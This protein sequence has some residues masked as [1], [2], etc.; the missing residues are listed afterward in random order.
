MQ[1]KFLVRNSGVGVEVNSFI[2]PQIGMR[3]AASSHTG[4]ELD[5][6]MEKHIVLE[7]TWWLQAS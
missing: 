6:S 2:D 5:A 4:M 1:G 7:A 3:H